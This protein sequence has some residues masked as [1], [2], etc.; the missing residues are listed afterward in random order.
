M[1]A[2]LEIKNLEKKYEKFYLNHIN[3]SIP[4]GTIMG[5]VGTNGAGK[6]TTMKAILQLVRAD[7]G[8]VF[9]DGQ[10]INE[11]D[12]NWKEEIGVVLDE[13]HFYETLTP[14]K[15]GNILKNAY[16]KW[17]MPKYQ[18][19]LDQFELP[20]DQEIK[21]FSKGMKV[22]LSLATAMS[23]DAKLLILDEP[24]SGLDPI[25]RDEILDCFLDFVQNEENSILVS[26]HITTDLEKIADYITFINQGNLLLTASKDE[27]LY[28]Y[29]ILRCKKSE[30][31]A[32]EK[33]DI[34]AYK[35]EEYQVNVLVNQKERMQKKYK[36]FIMD[37]TTLDEIMLLFVKGE[38]Y[39]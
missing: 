26:S 27:L 31:E 39:L 25:V 38:V 16:K 4:K 5:F 10:K 22:K 17:N 20:K 19:Y 18:Q 3:L 33:E 14:K 23:H 1:S 30:F 11:K 9:I 34:L 2:A 32:I 24:T 15:V 13:I 28:D 8:E 35:S 7:A 6:S 37:S 36:D 12:I 29:G 21:T